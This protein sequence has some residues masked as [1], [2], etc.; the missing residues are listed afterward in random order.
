MVDSG[1]K[2]VE[3]SSTHLHS[4]IRSFNLFQTST[5][6]YLW[7]TDI[8]SSSWSGLV[9]FLI[10]FHLNVVFRFVYKFSFSYVLKTTQKT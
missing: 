2:S 6:F 7:S 4:A 10:T 3:F 9:I 8:S 1:V 5:P